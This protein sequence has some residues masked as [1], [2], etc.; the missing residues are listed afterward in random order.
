M[1]EQLFTR[2]LLQVNVGRCYNSINTSILLSC[3]LNI[4]PNSTTLFIP[5]GI[6]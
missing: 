3:V 2:P 1:S 4:K 5:E 6:S